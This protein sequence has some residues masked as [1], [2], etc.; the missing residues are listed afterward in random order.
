MIKIH[1]HTKQSSKKCLLDKISKRL[2]RLE[3]KSNHSIK[4]GCLKYDVPKILT[5]L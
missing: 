1:R 2:S 3:F 4:S 5:S